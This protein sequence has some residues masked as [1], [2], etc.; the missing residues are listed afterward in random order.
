[1]CYKPGYLLIATDNGLSVINVNNNSFDTKKIFPRGLQRGSGVYVR[2]LFMDQRSKNIYINYSGK[3]D[4][5]DTDLN[6]LY[7]LTDLPWARALK[8]IEMNNA[9]CVKDRENRIWMPSDNYGIVLVDEKEKEVYNKDNNPMHYPFLKQEAIRS[10]FLEEEKQFICY[11][12]WGGGL[13]KYDFK[14]RKIQNQYF[15]IPNQTESRCINAIIQNNGSLT[16]FGTQN[17]YIVDEE[18]LEFKYLSNKLDFISCHKAFKDAE[19]TWIGTEARGLLQWPSNISAFRQFDLPYPIHDFTNFATAIC[20]SANGLL[21]LAYGLDGLLEVNEKT[22]NLKQYKLPQLNGKTQTVFRVCE[23]GE[24][25]LWIGTELGFYLFDKLTK[26]FKRPS[27]LPSFTNE[28]NVKYML[29]DS[30]GNICISFANPSSIGYYD[31]GKEQFSYFKN[32]IVDG[33]SMFD[34]R[35][36]ISRMV[37]EDNGNIW[38]ISY[39]GGGLLCYN[40]SQNQWK[41]FANQKNFLAL[42]KKQVNSIAVTGN[43]IWLS[44]LYGGGLIR[45]DYTNDSLRY[46]TRNDGL[47]SENIFSLSKNEAGQLFLVTRSGINYLNPATPEISSLS[48]NLEDIDWGFANHQYYDSANKEL[49][50]GLNDRIVILKDKLWKS[51][52]GLPHTFIN[53]IKVNNTAFVTDSSETI[54]LDYFQKNISVDFTAINYNKNILLDYAYKM[55][56]VDKDW[57][58]LHQISIANYAN[59]THGKYTFLVKAKEQNGLWGPAA[60]LS[61]RIK[62]AF[63][64]NWWFL[65]SCMLLILLI[66]YWLVK[67]RIN[68]IRR[69]ASL[70]QKIAETEMMA[71]R[72]QMNPHFI[73]NCLN[74]IDNLI[75]N[76]EKEKA[77]LYLSKFAKLI[78][79]IL[80]TSKNSAVP[81]WKDMETLELYVELEALRW[82][83]KIAYKINIA[84]DILNGDYKVPPLVIQP[85]VENAIH[86]G[87]LN[88]IEGDRK[89]SIDVSVT[90]NLI[91]Y[92]IEDNGVGRA[93]A[94]SYKELNKPTHESMGMQITKDRINL[95][96]QNNNAAIKITDLVNESHQPVGTRV[97]VDLINQS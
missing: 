18:T 68:L 8:G 53:S 65:V 79:S 43:I 27:W 87:L 57:N 2:S 35:F 32:Y 93:R 22:A 55:N 78:R 72:A 16:C 97:E 52:T 49:V 61:I 63:W 13:T 84:E 96:N 3:I 74:S 62:P 46:F 86:H 89:L 90:G 4:V 54:S 19:N 26:Q 28:L 69:E 11:S 24:S 95:F 36:P 39:L 91:H 31:I 29:R 14:S 38:M 48:I 85:F 76:N 33:K 60:S 82:D 1:L 41:T 9:P 56:G 5:F 45:Y 66:A 51:G 59:L 10:F 42:I 34:E 23:D 17:I 12:T 94:E 20:R 21:Y 83:K 6:F 80:E 58:I 88:K 25:R 37:E 75:Q 44:N 15:D 50:Y 70:K 81:C 40:P 92:I 7:R 77:T 67:K 64:Q 30:K 73:F 71:L 47:I